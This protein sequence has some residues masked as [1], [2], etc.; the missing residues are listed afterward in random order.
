MI[1]TINQRPPTKQEKLA[2]SGAKQSLGSCNKGMAKPKVI[3]ISGKTIDKD[4]KNVLIKY[5]LKFTPIPQRNLIELRTDIRKFCRK[6]RLIEFFA[7]E[8]TIEDNSLVK[9]ESTFHPNRNRVPILDTYIDFLLKYPLEEKARQMEK[10]KYNLTKQEWIGIKNLKNDK[11]LVVKES[12]KGG[13]CVVMNSEFYGRK[14]RQILE[15]ETTYKKLN[16]NIDKEVLKKIEDLTAMHDKELTKKEVK[17]LTNFDYKTSQLYGL[18]KVHKSMKINEEI[19][20]TKTEY[21]SVLR[22]T[23]MSFRP[24]IAGP[25]CVTSRLSN[26]LDILL[27]P[28]IIHIKSYI[29]DDIDFLDKIRKDIDASE[30]MLTLD[31]TSMYTNIDNQLGVEAITYWVSKDP[32]LLPRNISKDFIINSLKIVLEYNTFTFDT[33]YYIQVRGTAM[34]TKVAPTYATLVM[35]FIETRLYEQ[36]EEK[37]GI[38]IKNHFINKWWRYLD[39][40]FLIWTPG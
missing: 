38:N 37:Y 21:I 13:A 23:D 31:V 39:D 27:K 32:N 7:E 35:G 11:N 26:F 29:R 14:M 24:I 2:R 25:V 9:P 5:G 19:Q 36:I 17:Y 1:P 40:C 33:D 12:D 20:K 8:P 3:N 4:I 28:Y 6:L 10:V 15:D 18:P 34:G 22:P 30:T 16:K